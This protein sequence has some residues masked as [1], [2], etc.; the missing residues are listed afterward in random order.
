M[1]KLEIGTDTVA[2][3][4]TGSAASP[5]VR[6]NG[7]VCYGLNTDG[8]ITLAS[9]ATSALPAAPASG[10]AFFDT[11]TNTVKYW[12]GS[13]YQDDTTAIATKATTPTAPQFLPIIFAAAPQSLSGP[14]AANITAFAT[15][16]TTTD[17]AEAVTLANGTT[18]GQLKQI[19]HV[20]DGGSAV[21]TPATFADGDTITF[22]TVGERAI[23]LWTGSTWQTI[24]LSNVADGGVVLPAIA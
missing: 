24:D 1:R 4:Y 11:D 3:D 9:F 7:N 18:A 19:T 22:T 10:T 21:L 6:N 14:G 17:A 23:L 5:S 2:I 20:V 8:G 16:L 13:A 12:D 15:N